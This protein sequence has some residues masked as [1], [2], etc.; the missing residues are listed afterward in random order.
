MAA[1]QPEGLSPRDIYRSIKAIS[2]R[3]DELGRRVQ[4]YTLELLGKLVEMGKGTLEKKGR[5]YRFF[6]KFTRPKE[7]SN[8]DSQA[9]TLSA[10]DPNNRE[11]LNQAFQKLGDSGDITK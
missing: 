8:S 4:A 10:Q 1:T 3:A 11:P 9:H 2:R 7:E 5:F 6:A